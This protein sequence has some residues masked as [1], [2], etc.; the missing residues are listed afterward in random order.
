MERPAGEAAART[1]GITPSRLRRARLVPEA[2]RR[3]SS[4]LEPMTT[5]T[6]GSKTWS[7]LGILISISA[8]VVYVTWRI[9]FALPPTGAR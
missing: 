3:G 7:H 9:V 1:G 8:L 4:G 5:E 6:R 2:T